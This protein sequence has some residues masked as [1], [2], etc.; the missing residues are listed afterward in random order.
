MDQG[1]VDSDVGSKDVKRFYIYGDFQ[2]DSEE[3]GKDFQEKMKN[4]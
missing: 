1:Q 4:D 2:T 3:L